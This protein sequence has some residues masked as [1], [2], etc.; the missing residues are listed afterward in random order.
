MLCWFSA[1]SV[2]C[3]PALRTEVSSQGHATTS[4]LPSAPD[5][6]IGRRKR[7]A[8]VEDAWSDTAERSR[9]HLARRTSQQG[10]CRLNIRL[11][12]S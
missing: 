10:V 3:I 9:E 11:T 6:E 4:V 8:V 7:L 5:D 1:V 2:P 12:A